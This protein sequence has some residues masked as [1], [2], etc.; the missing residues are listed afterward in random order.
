[1]TTPNPPSDT[2]HNHTPDCVGHC[3]GTVSESTPQGMAS[4]LRRSGPPPFGD[5]HSQRALTTASATT[6]STASA[7]LDPNH[8]HTRH[9]TSPNGAPATLVVFDQDTDQEPTGLVVLSV[10]LVEAML[11]RLGYQ[12]DPKDGA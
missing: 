3:V 2:P 8:T 6:A 9:W 10:E 11:T 1:M 7:T 5:R 4:R 12:R